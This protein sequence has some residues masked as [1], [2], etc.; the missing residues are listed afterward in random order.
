MRGENHP[1]TA[2]PALFFVLT[3]LISWAILL[4][5]VAAARDLLPF[6]L[7]QAVLALAGFGPMLA[8]MIVAAWQGGREGLAA[9]LGRLGRWR[10]AARWYAVALLGPPLLFI[11]ALA[12]A[13]LLGSPVDLA[14]APALQAA[15][16]QNVSPLI[17][18][19]PYFAVLFVT[20]LGEEVGWRGY[21][22]PALL[23][24]HRPLTAS[25]VLGLL[26]GLWHL[27]MTWIPAL[28]AGIASVPLGWFALDIVGM[29]V[30]FTWLFLH[31]DG[32]LLLANLLHAA[33]NTAAAFL[34]L[35]PPAAGDLRPFLA[36]MALKWLL[37]GLILMLRGR[38][39][40]R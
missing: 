11:L 10:V 15:R 16:A 39:L 25:L 40:R 37:V 13:A 31:S 24:Q 27:P 6:H 9:L 14:Q 2:A 30:L 32:S 28:G 4:P 38:A 23:A 33:N 35:L 20:L 1:S 3:F 22:L 36:N 18:L 5:E 12:L 7:P 26:W 19:L 34:P 17:L 21:A 29:S 8:A